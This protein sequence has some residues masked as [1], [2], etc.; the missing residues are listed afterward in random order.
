MLYAKYSSFLL[1]SHRNSIENHVNDKWY[2]IGINNFYDFKKTKFFTNF[3]YSFN[4][5]F[6]HKSISIN[7]I[8]SLTKDMFVNF[9]I[10]YA[11]NNQT[12]YSI[13]V[14]VVL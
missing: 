6:I 9:G 10:G 7:S 8:L 1:G 14:G 3:I 4:K 11:S 5:D 2:N 12:S 13:E